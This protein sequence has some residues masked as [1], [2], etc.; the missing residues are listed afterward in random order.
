MRTTGFWLTVVATISAVHLANGGKLYMLLHL[1]AFILVVF[2]TVA[3]LL[4]GTGIHG[5]IPL[6]NR[7]VKGVLTAEDI[8]LTSAAARLGFFLAGVAAT[9][10][11]LQAL[12]N[13]SNVEQLGSAIVLAVSSIL[14]AFVQAAFLIPALSLR[15]SPKHSS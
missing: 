2:P 5:F 7:V 12:R 14:Y 10:G 15:S 1:E 4:R 9:I 8:A 11:A 6:G 13:L 3:F